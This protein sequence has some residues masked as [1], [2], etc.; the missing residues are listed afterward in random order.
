VNTGGNDD[1]RGD[2][3]Y[4]PVPP[5]VLREQAE[6]VC[7]LTSFRVDSR[8]AGL[9]VAPIARKLIGMRIEIRRETPTRYG[10]RAKAVRR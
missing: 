1:E 5:F 6:Q 2:A 3:D 10:S 4:P 9:A 7:Q 8:T